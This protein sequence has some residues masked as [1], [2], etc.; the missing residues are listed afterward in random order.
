MCRTYERKQLYSIEEVLSRQ[1][2]PLGN[3]KLKVNRVD[4]DG[5]L[6][7]MDSHRYWVFNHKGTDCVTCGLKGY[8][9]AKERDN[10]SSRYHFNLYGLDINGIEV[11]MTKDHIIPKS[12][13]GI[14]HL[15]NYNPMCYNCNQEKGDRLI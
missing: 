8:Y 5:D 6:I 1:I 14:N 11:M 10:D 13:G 12:K 3:R 4:F 7:S 9:F 15:D 2:D